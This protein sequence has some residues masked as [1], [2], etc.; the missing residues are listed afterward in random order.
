MISKESLTTGWI[1]KVTKEN[2]NADPSLVEKVIRALL[3]LEGLAESGLKFTF[4]G[5]TALML[6]LNSTKRLSIDID[7][8]LSDT[9]DNLDEILA[10]FL[11]KQGFTRIEIQQRNAGTFIDK[12]H[13]KFYYKPVHKSYANEEPI[14]LDILFEANHYSQIVSKTIESKFI[15]SEGETVS[16]NIPSFEDL[17][18][19]KLTAFAPNTTGIPYFKKEDSK[20]MEIIKQLYDIGNLFDVVENVGTIKTTFKKFAEVELKYRNV[21]DANAESV[22][23]DIYQTALCISTR[24][25]VDAENFE[26]LQQGIQ[27]I[28]GFIFSENYQIEKAIIHAAKAA[29]V[30]RV[31]AKDEM[32]LERYETPEQI[33]DALVAQPHNTKL[34]KLKKTNPEAFFYWWKA[35]LLS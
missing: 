24:G 25:N 22:L 9:P 29:Y 15:I 17:L 11:E 26:Q 5:G 27:R 2:R 31:I 19:D 18:G 34:N 3:L 14:L 16:V 12:A 7:I 28:R 6:M 13:F 35:T 4:K 32:E 10:S 30:A 1:E 23:N 21:E 20:S 33:A 8:I